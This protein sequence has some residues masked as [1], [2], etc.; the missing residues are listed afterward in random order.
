MKV[1]MLMFHCIIVLRNFINS[2]S[3]PTLEKASCVSNKVNHL[4]MK[5]YPVWV[6]QIQDK[7]K[8]DEQDCI[9]YGV[10]AKPDGR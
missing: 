3:N 7:D 8:A 6:E 10:A 9:V 5:P 1:I 2:N 4:A